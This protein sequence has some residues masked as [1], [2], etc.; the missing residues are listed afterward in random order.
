MD[1]YTR[2]LKRLARKAKVPTAELR[3]V[4]DTEM[5]AMV[6]EGIERNNVAFLQELSSR[7][8]DHFD[9][10]ENHIALDKFKKF[11]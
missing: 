11:L 3:V 2:Y 5:Q 9:I 1:K 8:K 4:W 10:E 7:V 6:N